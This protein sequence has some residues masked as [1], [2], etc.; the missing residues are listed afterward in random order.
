MSND[1]LWVFD[2][3]KDD[4]NIYQSKVPA[5]LGS[6]LI[7]CLFLQSENVSRFFWNKF[8]WFDDQ[9]LL[10]KKD[11]REQSDLDQRDHS[12]LVRA[13][14]NFAIKESTISIGQNSS[15]KSSL[16]HE[17]Y[18]YLNLISRVI[19]FGSQREDRTELGT[20]SL[21]GAQFRFSWEM[22]FS[23]IDYQANILERSFWG[24]VLDDLWVNLCKRFVKQKCSHMG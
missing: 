5:Q 18:Q 24:V 20:R 7:H 15:K 23:I 13:P 14:Q 11:E 4:A 10:Q 9:V 1:L 17:E 16:F 21:F 22:V 19:E 3:M 6:L 8:F 2:H 12:D